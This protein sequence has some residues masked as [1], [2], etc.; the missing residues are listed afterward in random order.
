MK[1]MVPVKLAIVNQTANPALTAISGIAG[2][3]VS[4]TASLA[5]PGKTPAKIP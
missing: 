1:I 5:Q 3:N 2:Y 4:L